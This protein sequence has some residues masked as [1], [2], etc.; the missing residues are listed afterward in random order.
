MGYDPPIPHSGRA[1]LEAINMGI[2]MGPRDLA[3]R[4]NM[5]DIREGVMHDF[6]ADHIDSAFSA[7]IMKELEKSMAI[8][9]MEYYP[10]VSYRNIIVWRNCPHDAL[11]ESTPPHDIHGEPAAPPVPR[12]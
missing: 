4:C 10:G 9:G 7:V 12:A 5:V 2:E 11:P 1:P 6:S 3:I 8:P